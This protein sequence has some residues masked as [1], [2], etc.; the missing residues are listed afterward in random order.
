MHS[1]IDPFR[2]LLSILPRIWHPLLDVHLYDRGPISKMIHLE[3]PLT[4]LHSLP[5]PHPLPLGSRIIRQTKDHRFHISVL[6]ELHH[7]VSV[8]FPRHHRSRSVVKR[9]SITENVPDHGQDHR[10]H[11]RRE[12]HTMSTNLLN[13]HFSFLLDSIHKKNDRERLFPYPQNFFFLPFFLFF[14]L[15]IPYSP[16][17]L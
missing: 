3:L 17:R 5:T 1:S 11:L 2:K 12:N 8:H 9:N 7:P 13:L 15:L 4:N 10:D 16:I 14:F 6:D